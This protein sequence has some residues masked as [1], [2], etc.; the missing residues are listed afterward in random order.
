MRLSRLHG[1]NM[2]EPCWKQINNDDKTHT[3]IRARTITSTGM[4]DI[5]TATDEEQVLS[6]SLWGTMESDFGIQVGAVKKCTKSIYANRIE[7][8]QELMQGRCQKGHSCLDQTEKDLKELMN[9]L[10]H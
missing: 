1:A 3:A 10:S 7:T 9:L 6:D 4:K 5:M 2:F 8:V